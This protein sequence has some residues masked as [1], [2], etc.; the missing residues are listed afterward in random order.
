MVPLFV[1]V[2]THL[3]CFIGMLVCDSCCRYQMG[4]VDV[5]GSNDVSNSVVAV[6]SFF[7]G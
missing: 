7:D 3:V 4:H 5:V 1:T 2:G 6:G